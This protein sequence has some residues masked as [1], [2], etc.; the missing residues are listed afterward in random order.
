MGSIW[1]ERWHL[2]VA[3]V[4]AGIHEDDDCAEGEQEP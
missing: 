2:E 3:L 1:S 4:W